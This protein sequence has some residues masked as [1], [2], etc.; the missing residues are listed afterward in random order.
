MRKLRLREAKQIPRYPKPNLSLG[1][2]GC[3]LGI[4]LPLPPMLCPPGM[5]PGLVVKTLR[6]QI[7]SSGC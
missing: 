3:V 5:S 2:L 1:K 4:T 7:T 6:R